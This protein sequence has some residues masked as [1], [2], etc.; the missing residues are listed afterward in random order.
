MKKAL[1]ITGITLASLVGLVL[2][3]AGIAAAMITSSGRLTKMVRKYA[4]QFVN[5]EMQLGKAD[6]TL[7]KTFPNVGIAIE[8]VALINPM[9]GSYSAVSMTPDSVPCRHPTA[10]SV[11]SA[12]ATSKAMNEAV[13]PT[14]SEPSTAWCRASY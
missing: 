3:V 8:N 12:S 9:P 10:Y 6:L 7:F 5:C 4:P 2:V 1:K 11:P 13:F 14:S